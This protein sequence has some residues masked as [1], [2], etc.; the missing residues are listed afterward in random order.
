MVAGKTRD[1]VVVFLG[2]GFGKQGR[3]QTNNCTSF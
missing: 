2:V 1:L 3:N